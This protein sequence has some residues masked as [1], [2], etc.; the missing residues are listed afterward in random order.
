M[1]ASVC[2]NGERVF[3][4][5]IPKLNWKEGR[6]TSFIGSSLLI[7]NALGERVEYGYL[8]GISSAA[9]RFHFHPDW[10]PSAGDVT[11]GFDVSGGLFK[12]LGYAYET[13]IIDDSSF[14]EIRSLYQRLIHQINRGI[15]VPGINLKVCPEWGIITGYLKKRPGLLC[16]T[17]FDETSDYS[18]AVKL[19]KTDRFEEYRSGLSAF[20][21][22]IE[23]LR[24][25]A[26]LVEPGVFEH[27]E[28]HLTLFNCL[29]DARKAALNFLSQTGLMYGTGIVTGLYRSMGICTSLFH[30][31]VNFQASVGSM[32]AS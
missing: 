15:P 13:V 10:C 22:W 5:S 23:E 26:Q 19:G 7:L 31:V 3:I 6:D 28:V 24:K 27:H 9:F 4:E 14:D 29:L 12:S 17:Y 20:R 8:M 1:K 2:D 30:T 11:T 16:R 18:L 25:H 21:L 32:E